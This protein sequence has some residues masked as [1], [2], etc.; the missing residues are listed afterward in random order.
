MTAGLLSE[1]R[2]PVAAD[3]TGPALAHVPIATAPYGQPIQI[4]FTSTC[5]TG[6][7]CAARVYYRTTA[8]A[9]LATVP[10]ITNEGGFQVANLTPWATTT[11]DG[12]QAV[13]WVHAIPGAAA[14]TTG[15]D[16]FIEAESNGARTRFPGSTYASGTQPVG[17]YQHIHVLSPPLIN[18]APVPF[19]FADQAMNVDAQ[20]SCSSGNCQATLWYRKTPV[21]LDAAAGWASVGMQQQGSTSLGNAAALLTYRG[22]VPASSVDTTGVDYYIHVT[23][24][25]AQ[26]FHPGTTYEGYYAPRDGTRVGAVNHHV[27]VL[28]PPRL[29]HVPVETGTYRQNVPISAKANCPSTGCQATLYYR[30][31]PAGALSTAPFSATAMTVTRTTG[32]NGVD[33]VSIDGAIPA[34]AADTRGVDYFFSVTDGTTTSWWPGTSAVDGPGVWVDGTRALYHHVRIQEPPHLVHAPP[35][36]APA[37]E[38]L[39]IETE[40]T[41][42]TEGCSATLFYTSTPN[43]A[44]PYQAVAM[45]RASVVATTPATR[46][47]LWRGTIPAGQV[48]TRGL[49]YYMTASDGYTNTA[50][51]GTFYWGAYAPV[52]GSNPAPATARFVVRVVDPPH[53]VHV[54]VGFAFTGESVPIEARSNCATS[55]TATLHWRQTGQSWQ[56]S[57]MSST[58]VPLAYGNDFVTYSATIAG[59]NVTTVGLE[60]R[61]EINDGYVT[62]TTPTYPVVV[63]DREVP[64]H[65]VG[66]VRFTGTAFL[67][68][69]PCSQTAPCRGTFAGEWLGHLAGSLDNSSFEVTWR[70]TPGHTNIS[71]AFDYYETTCATPDGGAALGFASG[72][73]SAHSESDE[74]VGVYWASVQDEVPRIIDSITFNF[75]FTWTRVGTGAVVTL[76]PTSFVLAV[77]DL[78]NRTVLTGT[79]QGAATFAAE[80]ASNTQTPTCA[81]P[82]NDVRGAVAGTVEL[83]S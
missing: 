65:A 7:S 28:E 6:G 22:Q 41:C 82:L 26:A 54:P 51:P 43:T 81:T 48:T 38:D 75:S 47:E 21:T 42:A 79:Q 29:A 34:G 2:Q 44:G 16:Y 46:V 32:T 12:Q 4:S 45:S 57:S 55:C 5:P 74:A 9:A 67:P 59:A 62:E 37:L 13:E 78:G 25:H 14:T 11:L 58:A 61:I 72:T 3:T 33:V 56:A 39:V 40:L 63:R 19:A 64:D 27:H 60:Y 20:V 80:S 17:T 50:A 35:P 8:P 70:S 77:R 71:A 23:D 30:T 10:G 66:G 76:T 52:D 24:G 68:K 31:T 18:H 15:V 83:V 36:I 49:A 1:S 53:P 73:G 69:F